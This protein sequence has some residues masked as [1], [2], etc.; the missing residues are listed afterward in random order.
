ML[1]LV[2]PCHP[3]AV[4]W[5][6]NTCVNIFL[7]AALWFSVSI[8]WNIRKLCEHAQCTDCWYISYPYLFCALSGVA[9]PIYLSLISFCSLQYISRV[10]RTVATHPFASRAHCKSYLLHLILITRRI[11]L[12]IWVSIH[13]LFKNLNITSDVELDG[14]IKM[15]NPERS[16]SPSS[17]HL[18]GSAGDASQMQV[19]LHPRPEIGW[20]SGRAFS[21]STL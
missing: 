19:P 1:F 7:W 21:R 13:H 18:R 3:L 14:E 16:G 5:D 20:F 12:P 4:L 2:L 8:C 6:Q 10:P 15:S 11:S 9:S 17:N